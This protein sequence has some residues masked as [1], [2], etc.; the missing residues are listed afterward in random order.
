[1]GAK[2]KPDAVASE[3]PIRDAP[4][5]RLHR[6]S[7]SNFR[8]IGP[9]P[10][11]IELD[12]IVVLVGPNNSGKSSILRAYQVV[13]EHGSDEGKLAIE[14][15]PNGAVDPAHLP[16]IE[17]ETVVFDKTAPGERW[18]RTEPSTGEMFVRE[19]WT[20]AAPGAPKKVGWD[21]AARAWHDTEGPWGAPNVAQ[22]YRPKPHRVSAFQSPAELAD[23][24]V[25]LLSKAIAERVKEISKKRAQDGTPTEYEQLIAS[26]S[27]LRRA[28]AS[29]ATAAV[30]Q[31][32]AGIAE[33]VGAV[34]PGYSVTF[35]ARPDD[36]IEKALVLYKPAP[37]LKMGPTDGFHS[38]L[39]R[40]GSGAARTLIWAALRILSEHTRARGKGQG[41]DRPNLLLMDE[42]ELCLHP[43]AV[44]EACRVLY[45]LP[46]TGNWQ[47]MI[48][49]HSPVFI[50]LTRD[51]TSIARVE[52]LSDGNVH[53]T[54]LFRPTRARLDEDDRAELKLLNLCDP[55]VAEFFFG[56]RTVVVEGDT[57]F[58]AFR[59][60][61]SHEPDTYRGVHVVR[62]RGKAC[63]V[64]LCKILNQ[65]EKGYSVLHD[66]DSEQILGTRTKKS[67]RNPA[68]TVNERILE[69]TEEGRGTG[70]VRLLASL[71]N[72]EVAFFGEEAD[73][74]KPFS[75][76]ARLKADSVSHA[77]IADL[78]ESLL[79]TRVPPPA[80]ALAWTTLSQLGDAV[81]HVG[82]SGT[83]QTAQSVSV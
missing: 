33:M 11:E 52:R 10:V 26:I 3:A 54:T 36:E 32:R 42:P 13:M 48:T 56:G 41:N 4:R 70:K 83:S 69:V 53:G 78:L 19:K 30:E 62:A 40:Q 44:R 15:F 17:L 2:K 59:H 16:T 35:D 79:D 76:L 7:V 8:C 63:I 75:A 29:D 49:T 38:S 64:S 18:V 27:E 43:D 66:A 81:R 24:V 28:I 46:K 65:F 1:M 55:Y 6:L 12:D 37:V 25:E 71:P 5:P 50:D 20:W 61:I 77:R 74:E 57:E 9:V 68:W 47:V 34:F 45:D 51:N 22:A 39:E 72:F 73:G 58:T 80:G 31:V 82:V 23:E 67:R 60:V 21:V 14:D